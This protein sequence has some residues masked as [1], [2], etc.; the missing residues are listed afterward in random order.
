MANTGHEINFCLSSNR[1]IPLFH[2]L[3]MPM[4]HPSI[5]MTISS[6]YSHDNATTVGPRR[7]HP[8]GRQGK[9]E[10]DTVEANWSAR[11]CSPWALNGINTPRYQDQVVRQTLGLAASHGKILRRVQFNM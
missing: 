4:A 3:S 2:R 7:Q 10:M 8:A 11:V 5:H 1:M 6:S 9:D